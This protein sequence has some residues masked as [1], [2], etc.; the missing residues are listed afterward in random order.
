LHRLDVIIVACEA[1]LDVMR[2]RDE[3][4]FAL[5][6]GLLAAGSPPP[7]RSHGRPGGPASRRL[8]TQIARFGRSA[9]DQGGRLPPG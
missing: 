1:F 5:V 9:T 3:V 7:G 4:S 2:G 8:T 6:V